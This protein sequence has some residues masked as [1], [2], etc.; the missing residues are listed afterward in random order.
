MLARLKR[1]SQ[2]MFWKMQM[3]GISSVSYWS[4]V[5]DRCALKTGRITLVITGRWG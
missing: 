3:K 4:V 5:L 1:A 2:V